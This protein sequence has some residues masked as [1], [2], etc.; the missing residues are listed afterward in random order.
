MRIK[1]VEIGACRERAADE[2]SPSRWGTMT[3]RLTALH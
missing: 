3:R 1:P 2:R